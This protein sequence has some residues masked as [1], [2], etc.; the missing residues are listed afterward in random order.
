MG[1]LALVFSV[2]FGQFLFLLPSL[3]IHESEVCKKFYHRHSKHPFK[4]KPG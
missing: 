2:Y 3:V 1:L 4:I